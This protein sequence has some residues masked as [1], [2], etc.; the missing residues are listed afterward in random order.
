MNNFS[1]TNTQPNKIASFIKFLGVGGIA[2][3][4]QYVIY[5]ALVN[6]FSIEIVIASAAAYIISAIFNYL[7]NYH[8]TFKSQGAHLTTFIRFALCSAIGLL[9]STL[10]MTICVYHLNY[11]YLVS[12][13]MATCI[14]TLSN[15]VTMKTWAFNKN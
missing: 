3:A 6:F 7:A 1:I 10:I 14:T 5:L 12:Q 4:I 9:V 13:V 15:Y 11:H 8:F 2:T